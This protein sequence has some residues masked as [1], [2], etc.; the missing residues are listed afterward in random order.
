M[1]AEGGKQEPP[2]VK[3]CHKV[4][5][6]NSKQG[7]GYAVGKAGKARRGWQ[8]GAL[9]K[10]LQGKAGSATSNQIN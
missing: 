9:G 3:G 8:Q 5:K 4:Y 10:A 2:S 7:E 1:G 6:L